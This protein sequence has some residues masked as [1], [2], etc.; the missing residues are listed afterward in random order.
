MPFPSTL[1]A[2]NFCCFSRW[3]FV[4][5]VPF[6]L[7]FETRHILFDTYAGVLSSTLSAVRHWDSDNSLLFG[8]LEMIT[9]FLGTWSYP[10]EIQICPGLKSRLPAGAVLET[11]LSSIP[12]RSFTFSFNDQGFLDYGGIRC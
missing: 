11:S 5:I 9:C 4:R 12:L 3:T 7:A 8:G 2:S 6:L 10:F 1:K